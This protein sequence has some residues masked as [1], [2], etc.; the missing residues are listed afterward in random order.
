SEV[1]YLPGLEIRTREGIGEVL[2]VICVQAGRSAMQV[3]HWETP[4]PSGIAN[5]QYRYNL[6]DHLG[7]SSLELDSE[8]E[9]I[10]QETYHPY[11]STAW[12]A[13]RSEVEAGYKTVRYSGK[14]RDATGLYYYGL[15]YYAPWLQRWINPDPE[16][17][18]DGLNV[19]AFVRGKPTGRIDQSGLW[20]VDDQQLA[21]F[22]ANPPR[23]MSERK[24]DIDEIAE[25]NNEY[26]TAY[27]L[28]AFEPD[29]RKAVA[30]VLFEA[31]LALQEA[32]WLLENRPDLSTSMLQDFFGV[33]HAHEHQ[34]IVGAW[35][36][37]E[38]MLRQYHNTGFGRGKIIRVEGGSKDDVASVDPSDFAGHI[39]IGDAFERRSNFAK[40]SVLIHEASHLARV[41][42]FSGV[43]A[44]TNDFYYLNERKPSS[45]RVNSSNIT[46][47]GRIKLEE[48]KSTSRS[49]TALVNEWQSQ[50]AGNFT[51]ATM[52][53]QAA[54]AAHQ[55]TPR[56]RTYMAARNADSLALSAMFL[57]RRFNSV[58]QR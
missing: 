18:V 13:G 57:S 8:A 35:E 27:G 22:R 55:T 34:T 30:D 3:L 48:I 51:G 43:G 29:E 40:V 5:N 52:S 32:R 39:F 31:P 10:S 58:Y 47:R 4:P 25:R 53:K 50:S 2:Q 54:L 37:T 6:T 42:R 36:R 26:V 9:V 16:G 17:D 24:E 49:F 11:G 38:K 15:R 44:S 21:H 33:D 46:V 12:F 23:A 28:D 14:E 56:L 19:Y 20:G 45:V 7:S 41:N 1:R